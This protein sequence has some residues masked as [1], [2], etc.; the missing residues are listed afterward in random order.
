MKE[1]TPFKPTLARR[2]EMTVRSIRT[3]MTPNTTVAK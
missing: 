2:D 3:F 1:R